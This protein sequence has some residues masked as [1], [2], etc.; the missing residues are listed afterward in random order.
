MQLDVDSEV[1]VGHPWP[2]GDRRAMSL[3]IIPGLTHDF[4][5]WLANSTFDRDDF[6]RSDLDGGSFGGRRAKEQD[7]DGEPV[8]F[9]HGNGDAALGSGGALF[10]GWTEVL[11]TFLAAGYGFE[12]L[13]GTTWGPA[14]PL[15]ARQQSHDRRRVRRVRRFIEAVLEYT[16]RQTVSVVAHS[17]GVT[18]AR[19]AILG[20]RLLDERGWTSLGPTL[21]PRVAAFIGIAGANLGLNAALRN[22]LVRAWNPINGFFPGVSSPVGQVGV[23]RLLK[24]INRSPRIG[25]KVYSIWSMSDAI[26]DVSVGGLPSGRI[27]L[28]DEELVVDGL[29]HFEVK[30][31]A[32]P[33]LL[34]WLDPL[35]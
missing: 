35:R 24:D 1:G 30:D 2:K 21:A 25:S 10:N 20:G 28:Q 4:Q 5:A 19:K 3:E 26:V 16:G 17:M 9:V 23:S 11:G 12:R 8:I 31:R 6:A 33:H 15:L 27:P 22:P 13:Y 34:E 18:L 7:V 29:N 32:G 14:N